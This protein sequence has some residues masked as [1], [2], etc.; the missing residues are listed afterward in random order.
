MKK[1]YLIILFLQILSAQWSGD[2]LINN[3]IE[4][5]DEN[6]GYPLVQVSQDGSVYFAWSDRRNNPLYNHRVR[7]YDFNGND[8]EMYIVSYVHSSSVAGIIEDFKSDKEN[9]VYML[10]EQFSD[11]TEGSDELRLQH[12]NS[13]I[14]QSG[15]VFV[16]YG[17]IISDL[18]CDRKNS[19]LEV[20]DRDNVMVSYTSSSCSGSDAT[21][22][23]NAYIQKISK[24]LLM[25]ESHGKLAAPRNT[26]GNDVLDTKLV[27]GPNNGAFILF[28]QNTTT[29]NSLRINYV[30]GQGSFAEGLTYPSGLG[31][32]K[33]Y[34]RNN[35]ELDA[36][37]D[38]SNGIYVV[39]RNSS[40]KI[41]LQ[42]VA[43]I[44]GRLSIS[45]NTFV[46]NFNSTASYV[47][48]RLDLAR[49]SASEKGVFI[50]YYDYNSSTNAYGLFSKYLEKPDG[51][52][53]DPFTVSTNAS[54][55]NFSARQ[56]HHISATEFENEA[57]VT[58]ISSDGDI[59]A[60]KI[61]VNPTNK[62]LDSNSPTIIVHDKS[63]ASGRST[64]SAYS[65]AHDKLGG[66]VITWSQ[67]RGNNLSSDIFAQQ[68]SNDG[69]FGVNTQLIDVMGEHEIEEDRDYQFPFDFYQ[70]SIVRSLFDFVV[71]L[72]DQSVKASIVNDTIKLDFPENWNGD[73]IASLSI[74]WVDL[75]LPNEIDTFVV[76]V[77]PVQDPPQPFNWISSATDTI[78]ITKTNFQ[79]SYNLQW[80]Q[81]IDVDKDSVN[82]LV[83]AKIGTY[84]KEEIYDTTVTTLPIPYQE[85]LDNVFEL[86]P[87]PT[88]TVRFSVKATDG[89]DTVNVTGEDRVVYVNRYEYLSTDDIAAP[90]DFA[91]HDNYPNPFNPTTQIRFDMPIMGDVRLTIYNM[92]GQKVKEYQMNGLSA[93]S[94]TLTWDATNDLGDPIGVGIYFYQ[95]Q[96]KTFTKTKRMVLLK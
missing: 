32:G 67:D 78:N 63:G 59:L 11:V 60:K 48:P 53:S 96:T 10:W 85:L 58:W 4:S 50:L 95:L 69:K 44:N 79:D 21:S 28:S 30:D 81:S 86:T 70:S 36:V 84:P 8:K 88:A 71:N 56:V 83:S 17:L 57:F 54:S 35:W 26:N 65:V 80:S 9:G 22:Y 87:G 12:I 49:T 72:S 43:L 14:E 33:L 51:V 92:L 64:P 75:L 62:T 90:T 94:H 2:S 73:L 29:D 6:Q 55:P 89:I 38:G 19:S 20:I 24:G 5:A 74:D 52:V 77:S 93:G 15:Q 18:E 91:L 41:V 39:F 1:N 23:G 46:Q 16:N 13:N 3:T 25:W 47:Y 45:N 37:S 66:L 61:F 31:L 76:K 40:N 7:K 82:Y 27:R 34:N 68:V 42:H